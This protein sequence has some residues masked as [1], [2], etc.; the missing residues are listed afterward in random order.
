M[1]GVTQRDLTTQSLNEL[2]DVANIEAVALTSE[3]RDT[4]ASRFRAVPTS[5]HRRIDAWM[6]ERSGETSNDFVWSPITARRVLGNAALRYVERNAQLS[7]AEAVYEALADQLDRAARGHARGGSLG[8]W[9]ANLESPIVGIVVAEATT[10]ATQVHQLMGRLGPEIAM[11][12]V[13]AYYDIAG[14][15]TSLRGRRDAIIATPEGRIVVRFRSGLPGRTAGAG[16]RADLV[17]DA[18]SQANGQSAKRIIGIWPEAGVALSLDG[19]M[20]TL[21]AGARDLVRSAVVEHRS[22]QS[23]AA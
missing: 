8:L 1:N 11:A 4:L 16:L 2:I 17:V 3:Q 20:E 10:W 15:R 22:R 18:L 6:V 9:L 7:Y 13:D 12:T 21:R 14:A 19:T 23:I 5:Q